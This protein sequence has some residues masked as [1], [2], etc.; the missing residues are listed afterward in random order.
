LQEESS[1]SGWLPERSC[2]DVPGHLV[3]IEHDPVFKATETSKGPSATFII[4]R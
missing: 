4:D 3:E 1:K 2:P